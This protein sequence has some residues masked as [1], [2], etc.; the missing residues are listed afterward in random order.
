VQKRRGSNGIS[1]L[2]PGINDHH[3]RYANFDDSS[4]CSI[5]DKVTAVTYCD[6]NFSQSDAMKT[7]IDLFVNNKV[8]ANKQH[9]SW[10][11]VEQ[12]ADLAKVFK[13]IKHLLPSHMVKNI[14]AERCPMK[15]LK[16]D[17]FKDNLEYLN[18]AS[19][20]RHSLIDS[21]S[22]LS[23]MATKACTVKIFEH[24]FIKTG[25]IDGDNLRFP[26]FDKINATCRWSPSVKESKNIENNINTFIHETCEN[27]H[28]SE[29]VYDGLNIVRD[30]DSMGCEVMR[31]ATI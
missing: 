8:I 23:V 25:M 6:G 17:A 21:K 18:L 15:A 19:N 4:M 30:R 27:G 29:E 3:K 28:I 16:L 9:A 12:P 26:V 2:L 20:K 5:P 10:L 13:L 7:S 11:G 14:P 31:D 22:T 24:G 1:I